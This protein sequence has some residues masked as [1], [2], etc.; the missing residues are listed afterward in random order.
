MSNNGDDRPPDPVDGI[1]NSSM[2][3]YRAAVRQI[4]ER[5]INQGINVNTV[6]H[7]FDNVAIKELMHMVL[8][9]KQ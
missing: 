1:D 9:R 6:A 2:V 5:Q 3:T 7:V 4:L 8:T